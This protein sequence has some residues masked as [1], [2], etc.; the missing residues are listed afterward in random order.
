[1]TRAERRA[2]FLYYRGLGE[3][4]GITGIPDDLDDM[5]RLNVAYEAKHFRFAE[6]NRRISEATIRLLLGLFYLPRWLMWAGRP[7]VLRS[8]CFWGST[9]R[10][11]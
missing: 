8:G 4:M 7:T 2:W 5:M 1:M 10:A 3:R 6:T 11:G 9:C